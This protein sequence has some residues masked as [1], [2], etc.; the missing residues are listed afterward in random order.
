MRN[1]KYE[2]ED[3]RKKFGK[4]AIL[5]DHFRTHTK[6][7]PFSCFYDNCNKTFAEKG[8]MKMHYQRHL[9]KEREAEK[10]KTSTSFKSI[11]GITKAKSD[12]GSMK[13]EDFRIDNCWND[14][15]KDLCKNEDK[16]STEFKWS[17]PGDWTMFCEEKFSNESIN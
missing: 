5:N 16:K 7:K 3:C 6:E 17:D 13:N 2:C 1:R 12:D 9:K 10:K 11:G 8:N 14:A 4:K 15:M